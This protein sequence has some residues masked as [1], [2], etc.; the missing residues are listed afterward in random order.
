MPLSIL[1]EQDREE[2]PVTRFV[3]RD[4]FEID[5]QP[6]HAEVCETETIMQPP[7]SYD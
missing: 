1:H 2:L 4:C 6:T 3:R 5:E 7:P